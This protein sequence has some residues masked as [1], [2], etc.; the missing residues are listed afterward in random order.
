MQTFSQQRE[1]RLLA[2][3]AA[4]MA[5]VGGAGIFM[6]LWSGSQAILTDGIFSAIAVVI[7]LL[8]LGT[9]RLIARETSVRFQF[10]YWQMEPLVLVAEGAFTLLVVIVAAASGIRGLLGGGHAVDFGLAV[11]F[12]LFFEALSASFYV[13]LK[14]ENRT[15]R[16]NLVRFDNVSWYVDMMLAGGLLVSFAAA[17]ALEQT[18]WAAWSRYADPLVM[19]A[20]SLHMIRPALRILSPSFRQVLGVA[21]RDVHER[22]QRVMDELMESCGFRDYV[23]SV[24]QYGH[25]KIIEIDILVDRDYPARSAADFDAIRDRI[26][27]ALG[28]PPHQQWL[29]INFTAARRWMARDYLLDGKS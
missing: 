7:K 20:L 17:W 6:G 1:Q 26:D 18:P 22:V 9:S 5:A 28:Y 24:Q 27:R 19:L 3:S 8:M 12:A 25:T 16:S 15:L 21:P 13:Y 14:Q 10:G 29:T 4:V 11:Y 2:C 23:S